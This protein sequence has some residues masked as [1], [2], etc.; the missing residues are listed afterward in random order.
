MHVLVFTI[1]QQQFAFELSVI[2][3]VIR[4]VEITSQPNAPEH[5]MGMI[6]VQGHVIPVFNLRTLLKLVQKEIDLSDQLIICHLSNHRL[7]LWVD[8]VK[9]VES[10]SSEHFLSAKDVFPDEDAMEWVIKD[11]RNVTLVYSLQK[12]LTLKHAALT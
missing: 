2:E 6:N 9:Q 5:V 7:A 12:L 10:Y 4:I 11:E 1:D 8:A 3:R